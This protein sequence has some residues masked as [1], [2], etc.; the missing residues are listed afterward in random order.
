MILAMRTK[1][2]IDYV[3][4]DLTVRVASIDWITWR[5][6]SIHLFSELANVACAGLF[7]AEAYTPAIGAVGTF[8]YNCKIQ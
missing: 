4:V 3:L 7:G 6:I 2:F 8:G 5:A 1:Q